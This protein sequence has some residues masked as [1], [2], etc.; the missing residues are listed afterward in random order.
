MK[1]TLFIIIFI[2]IIVPNFVFGQEIV[3]TRYYKTTTYYNGFIDI[4][5]NN[6]INS[7]TEEITEEEF[8]N[9]DISEPKTSTVETTI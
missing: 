6:I 7:T 4:N 9:A 1:K 3:E 2:S 8:Q 5:G